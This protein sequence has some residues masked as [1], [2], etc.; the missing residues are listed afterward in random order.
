M[1][2]PK[3]KVRNIIELVDNIDSIAEKA[4]DIKLTKNEFIDCLR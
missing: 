2:D 4:K 3:E 1:R